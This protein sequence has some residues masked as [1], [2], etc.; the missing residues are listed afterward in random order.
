MGCVEFGMRNGKA[1]R[2]RGVDRRGIASRAVALLRFC[3][4][5]GG[6][7]VVS[8]ARGDRGATECGEATAE[9]TLSN[10]RESCNE[11]GSAALAESARWH[12]A[13]VLGLVLG[14]SQKAAAGCGSGVP[15]IPPLSPLPRGEGQPR[16][17]G[18]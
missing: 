17:K 11:G 7:A 12:Y 4:S 5:F 3:R 13:H 6:Q 18:E 9:M 10:A 8:K 14:M 15:R 2:L 16:A 1:W